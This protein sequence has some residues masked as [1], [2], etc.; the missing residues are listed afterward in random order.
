MT[1]KKEIEIAELSHKL[2]TQGEKLRDIAE[3]CTDFGLER[4]GQKLDLAAVSVLDICARL[5]ELTWNKKNEVKAEKK[6]K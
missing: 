4:L 3:S 1:A 6:T 5:D 2:Y